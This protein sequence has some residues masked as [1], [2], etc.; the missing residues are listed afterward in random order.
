MS[1]INSRENS[2]L[3]FPL[4]LLL[5]LLVALS[6][7]AGQRTLAVDKGDVYETQVKPLLRQRCFACHGGLKQEADLRLDTV[8][9]MVEGGAVVEGDPDASLLLERV[10]A[11]NVDERMP[12]EHEGEP[13]SA[14]QIEFLRQWIVDGAKGPQDEHPEDDPR[15]HWAFQAIKRPEVP[16]VENSDWGH[17]PIDSFIAYRHEQHGLTPQPDASQLLL[18][19]RLSLDLIGLPPTQEQIEAALSDTSPDWYEQ[20]VKRLLDDPRHGERWARHW[21]DIWRYS[22]WWGLGQQLRNSQHHIWH[23]RDWIIE[24]LNEDL[25]YDEM[26]RL[27]LAADELHPN[28]L[29]KLRATG[30]L[31]RNYFLFNRPQWMEETVEHVSKGF[32]GLTMNCSKCHDHK[33]DPFEQTDFYRMRAFFEPYHVRLDMVPGETDLAKDGIPRVFDA[34]LDQPT[35]VYVRGNA[36]EPDESTVIA[37]G[38]PDVLAFTEMKIEPVILPDEAWQPARRPWVLEDHLAVAKQKLE[39]ANAKLQKLQEQVK[40]TGEGESE[41]PTEPDAELQ[42]AELDVAVAEAELESVRQRAETMRGSWSNLDS[43]TL[44]SLKAA[45][46]NAERQVV[47]ASARRKLTDAEHRLSQVAEDKREAIEKEVNT[48][49]EALQKAEETLTSEI[50]DDASFTPLAG[51]QWTPTRFLF[52]GKDDPTPEFMPTSTGR[53]TAL[54]NWLTDRRNPL[55]ARVAVNHIWTRHMGKPLV[56]TVFDFGRNG[57][58]STHPELLDWLASELMDNNW[59]MKHLHRLIVNSATYRMSSSQQGADG[60]LAVDPEN[61]HWWRREPNR[62]ESQVVRDSIL[63]LAGT[64]DPTMGG[65]PV[66][67]KQQAASHRRSLYFFHSNN[68]RNLFLTTFDEALVKDC[69]RR[70]QSIVPQQA[71]ALSNSQLVLESSEQIAA[72]LG[73]DEVDDTKF[74]RTAFAALLGIDANEY[75]LAS[76]LSALAEW[77]SL[78]DSSSMSARANLVWALMNHNDFVTL[79]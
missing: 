30:Y 14:E 33:Y 60:N 77:Q 65:P 13:L 62:V 2:I 24:S 67:A 57:A 43:E 36:S 52:S 9:L 32:L 3:P 66:L 25:G 17:N 8:S 10:A 22:D 11:T 59:S 56:S 40:L 6:L 34:L 31:A 64:L 27:M 19:R 50:G 41:P 55:T 23:W 54:A 7:F 18:L 69:Y 35:Y 16:A 20:M 49:R 78:P 47:V 39:S 26:V 73:D 72:R 21:M 71:L 75:E 74:V 15:E 45:A 38:V 70:E 46:I 58:S 61:K 37:P 4:S 44:T 51:A 42:L 29:N 12:P 5:L 76:S 28:D 48:S 63:E 79:R 53:R 1:V 68:D